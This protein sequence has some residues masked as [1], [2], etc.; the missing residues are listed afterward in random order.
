MKYLKSLVCV[1]CAALA[2]SVQ[3]YAADNDGKD[4]SN[5]DE[6]GKTVRGP[7]HTNKFKDNWFI[8]VSAGFNTFMQMSAGYKSGWTECLEFDFGKWF[9]PAVGLRVGYQ[10]FRGT[11]NF[12]QAVGDDS[13]NKEKFGFAYIHGDALWNISHTIGGYRS[14]RLWNFV[15]YA[16]LG[17]MRLYSV[18]NPESEGTVSKDEANEFAFGAGLLN[19]IRVHERVNLTL[20]ARASTFSGRFHNWDL[21][22]PLAHVSATF[23]LQV[24]L[25]KTT[26]DRC[27]AGEDDSAALA[28]ALAALAAAKALTDNLNKENKDLADGNDAL[29]ADNDSLRNEADRLRNRPDTV[30]ERTDTLYN[31][32]A[33]GIAP[34]RLFF[35]INVSDL[36]ATEKSHLK[37][38]VE[39]VLE[40]DPDRVFYVSGSA[41]SG[42][43]N[44]KI[45][46]RLS[47]ERVRKTIDFIK[48]TYGIDE[49]RLKF[50]AA[51]ISDT[52]AG[53][54]PKLDRSVLIEH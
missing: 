16:H 37:Y 32:Y 47:N 39:N 4:H 9:T 35:D 51:N 40:K 26:W 41:D 10:G 17:Y 53:S 20:D 5:K 7:Y 30:V 3:A 45:N 36:S 23:G 8:G 52:P 22:H 12:T 13:E 34:F 19:L 27:N 24:L 43:G 31:E 25:G 21:G 49:S 18:D 33:L 50:K 14:D 44:N 46:T 38:Y 29:A 11:E 2:I 28:D 15:P 54:D 48:K 6:N 42:T 1:L